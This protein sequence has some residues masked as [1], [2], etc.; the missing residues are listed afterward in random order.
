MKSVFMAVVV[1]DTT[2]WYNS[3][4]RQ[5]HLLAAVRPGGG[6]GGIGKYTSTGAYHYAGDCGF[7]GNSVVALGTT[8]PGMVAMLAAAVESATTNKATVGQSMEVRKAGHGVV[9][10]Q[11]AIASNY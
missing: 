4:E 8:I 7:L 3:S 6:G 10:I 11:Y 9:I 1:V 2:Y 5:F